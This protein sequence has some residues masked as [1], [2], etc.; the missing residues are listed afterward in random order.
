MADHPP[1]PFVYMH[2]GSR[3]EAPRNLAV[4]TLAC[5]V[6][7]KGGGSAI[8]LSWIPNFEDARGPPGHHIPS[9]SPNRCTAHA[10][11]TVN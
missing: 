7:K 9:E 11:I 6:F 2:A 8:T 3:L 1:C 10:H 4:R 5:Q